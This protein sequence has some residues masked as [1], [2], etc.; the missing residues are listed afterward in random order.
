[1]PNY[2]NAKIYKLI[3]DHTDKIYIGSTCKRYLSNRLANHKSD[4]RCKPFVC[5][6]AELLKLGDVK[7]ILLEN[8]PCNDKN[9]LNAR[10]QYYIDQNKDICVNKKN[11]ANTWSKEKQSQ[12]T[13]EYRAKNWEQ[14]K[15][16]RK[17]LEDKIE[18]C[19]CGST[20]KHKNASTHK[21]CKK[22]LEYQQSI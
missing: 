12:Y 17:P 4:Y 13:K 14:M 11:P 1:M 7:I 3:S 15:A 6:S 16:Q 8:Y 2:Q 5:K 22:H 18:T 21:K 19:E 10:E 9:E 20:F